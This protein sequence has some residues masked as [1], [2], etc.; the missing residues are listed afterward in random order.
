MSASIMYQ[1][2]VDRQTDMA[3]GKRYR[4]E[5]DDKN[6]KYLHTHKTIDSPTNKKKNLFIF[7]FSVSILYSY[8]QN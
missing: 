1:P 3:N 2:L 4:R 7:I 8:R 5:R 6:A